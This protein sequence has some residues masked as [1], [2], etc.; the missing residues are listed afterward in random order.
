MLVHFS[1]CK[2]LEGSFFRLWY[3]GLAPSAKEEMDW[4]KKWTRKEQPQT[5]GQPGSWGRSGSTPGILAVHLIPGASLTDRLPKAGGRADWEE[6]A[7]CK[8]VPGSSSSPAISVGA[9]E[10]K[11]IWKSPALKGEHVQ[12]VASG[13]NLRTS[14]KEKGPLFVEPAKNNKC[15]WTCY[16]V[17]KPLYSRGPHLLTI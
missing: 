6:T 15:T 12:V 2:L 17:I 16:C 9:Q 5:G 4:R 10:T 3:H 13:Y 1:D 14:S 8:Y 11:S 7:A